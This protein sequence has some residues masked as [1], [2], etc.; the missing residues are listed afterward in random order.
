MTRLMLILVLLFAAP[1][2][3]ADRVDRLALAA[4]FADMGVQGEAAQAKAVLLDEVLAKI[5]D[6]YV[7]QRKSRDLVEAAVTALRAAPKQADGNAAMVAALE[8]VGK[9][10]DPHTLYLSPA[11]LDDMRVSLAGSFSGVGME[12]ALKDDAVTVVAPIDDTPAARAGIVAGDRLTHVDGQPVAGLSLTQVVAKIRGPTGSAVALTLLRVGGQAQIV[13]LKRDVIRVTAVKSRLE[14]EVGYVRISQ[15]NTG[16]AKLVGTALAE[17]DKAA[18]GRLAGIVLDLR[19]N[20]GGLLDQAI[21]VSDLFLGDVPIVSTAG[22]LPDSRQL[23]SGRPGEIFANLPM[24]VLIDGGSAS[25]AEI[26]A[27]ALHDNRRAVLVGQ[28]SYG[29]GSVQTILQLSQGAVKV[30]TARYLRPNTEPVDQIGIQPD[31]VAPEPSEGLDPQL[32]RAL[33]IVK[34]R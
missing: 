7:E 15:F 8:G 4:A 5:V 10:L 33:A 24:V 34:E 12:L 6:N 31:I 28:K 9:V 3:W 18:G 16:V 14:G 25:A 27:G 23:Y 29:K 19:R 26:V 21:A 22:R 11:D 17:L 32:Q 2:A 13:T 1:K 20:P 30:T